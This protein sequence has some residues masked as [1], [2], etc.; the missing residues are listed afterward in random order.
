M[1]KTKKK[2]G[3]IH[4]LSFKVLA[5]L[6][7]LSILLGVFLF[8]FTGAA[9]YQAMFDDCG[10]IGKN[11]ADATS[12]LID[13]ATAEKIVAEN[14]NMTEEYG[15]FVAALKN[16]NEQSDEF[17]SYL[18]VYQFYRVEE[19]SEAMI[20]VIY[21]NDLDMPDPYGTIFS[22]DEDYKAE[23]DTALRGP[24]NKET[25][26]PIISNGG[27][28]WLISVYRPVVD[29]NGQTFLYLR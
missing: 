11:Y 24:Y 21:D 22:M 26:G 6:P 4:S 3:F 16:F 29:A 27:W 12:V 28:G 14:G 8:W 17:I 15:Y 2:N 9:Y 20:R 5:V 18:Y 10:R 1:E 25:V 13:S 7:G 23:E 19:T